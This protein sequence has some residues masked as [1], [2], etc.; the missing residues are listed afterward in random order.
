LG[1][2]LTDPQA[3]SDGRGELLEA[4]AKD[5]D[6]IAPADRPLLRLDT[7]QELGVELEELKSFVES[8][9]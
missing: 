4:Q 6:P 1:I 3:F 5:F 7:N 8:Y 9:L 2:R